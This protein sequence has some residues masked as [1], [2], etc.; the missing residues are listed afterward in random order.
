MTRVDDMFDGGF[1]ERQQAVYPHLDVRIYA[2]AAAEFASR[3][4]IRNP[5]G[6][7]V[8]WLQRADAAWQQRMGLRSAEA[9]AEAD[10]YAELWVGIL[11]A[12]AVRGMGPA[13]IA[14]ALAIARDC[15]FVKQNPR[16]TARLL[17]LGEDWPDGFG[18]GVQALAARA[19]EPQPAHEARGSTA[20][21]A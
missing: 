19:A 7:L 4:V 21:R 6:L 5:N 8:H 15:G 10:R 9:A 20:R 1:L 18:P 12:A 14:R 13:A 2:A 11:H 17:E 16:I 3:Q